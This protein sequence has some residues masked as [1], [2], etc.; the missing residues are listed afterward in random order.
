MEWIFQCGLRGRCGQRI[1]TP[2]LRVSDCLISDLCTFVFAAHD[3]VLNVDSLT[4][5]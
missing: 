5:F 2:E 1:S 4:E 3:Y